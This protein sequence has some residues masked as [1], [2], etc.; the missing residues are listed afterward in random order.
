VARD[1]NSVVAL[2]ATLYQ[3]DIDLADNDRRVY[4]T[5]SI[6]AAKHPSESD[7]FLVARVLAYALEY[8]EGIAFSKGGI[9]SPDE[10]TIAI[11]DLTGACRR[12]IEIG[13]PEPER[14]HRASKV[15]PSVAV[16]VHRDPGRW[17]ARLADERIHR[18]EAIEIWALDRAILA[19]LVERLDRRM[20]FAL[21]V[22]DR[23]LFLSTDFGTLTGATE[24]LVLS[25]K[26]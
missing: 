20:A 18:A 3:F 25:A 6:R 7:D 24:R 4:E 9:S 5:V 14:L 10:P 19:A 15:A 23:D 16:Y 21:S 26:G 1:Y 11:R 22:T 2:T 8:G 17:L 13:S 12:W